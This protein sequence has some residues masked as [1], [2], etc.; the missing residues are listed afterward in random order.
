M[1]QISQILVF[2]FQ[3]SVF[4]LFSFIFIEPKKGCIYH[5]GDNGGFKILA[6]RYPKK[7]AFVLVFAA[8]SDW[9]RYELK[10]QIEKLYSLLNYKMK[11]E[12]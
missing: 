10:S 6:S 8:R 3:N 4:F 5:T 7:N 9:D 12:T 1:N 11:W 2:Y